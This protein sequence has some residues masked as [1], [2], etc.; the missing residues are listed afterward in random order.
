MGKQN[1]RLWGTI[2]VLTIITLLST[3]FAFAADNKTAAQQKRPVIRG[4]ASDSVIDL[5][6]ATNISKKNPRITLS[7]KDTDVK[8][9]LRMF[10][11]KAGINLILHPSVK[12]YVNLD[13]PLSTLKLLYLKYKAAIC[14][15]F[16]A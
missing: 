11:D 13:F 3:T 9:V 16:I 15:F 1:R 14:G 4:S 6:G 12:G 10:A 5:R 7:L 8:P 2:L